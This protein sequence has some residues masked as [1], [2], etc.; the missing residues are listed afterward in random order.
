[1]ELSRSKEKHLNISRVSSL[2]LFR[3]LAASC[4]LYNRIEPVKASLFV[5]SSP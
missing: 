2:Y 4:V 1:M 3:A 5:N